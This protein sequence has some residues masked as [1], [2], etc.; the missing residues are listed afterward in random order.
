MKRRRTGNMITVSGLVYLLCR[1]CETWQQEKA[2][3]AVVRNVFLLVVIIGNSGPQV[4]VA[5]ISKIE[6][7]RENGGF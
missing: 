7:V 5:E 4:T 2:R 1:L 3:A 6:Y